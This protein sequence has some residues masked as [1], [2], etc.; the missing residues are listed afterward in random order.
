MAFSDKIKK[1]RENHGLTQI[2]LA[3]KL[4]VTQRTISYYETGKG[5]PNIDIL[6]LLAKTFDVSLDYLLLESE[7]SDIKLYALVNK[8]RMDTRRN[9]LI[10]KPSTD[11]E[12]C[13][14]MDT[15][16]EC[17]CDTVDAI[18]KI[19]DFKKYDYLSIDF[20]NSYFAEYKNGGYLLGLITTPEKNIT[21]AL[22]AYYKIKFH[23]LADINSM[24]QVEELYFEVKDKCDGLGEFL[25]DY[26][27]N[28]SDVTS[29]KMQ[30]VKPERK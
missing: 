16:E 25:N 28:S 26:L 24:R 29:P 6:N 22:F 4:G 14:E 2:D 5:Q 23:L 13:I 20:E 12:A 1:L 19:E 21:I 11:A 17:F 8:L 10:W 3:K 27:S 7:K 9:A 15:T 18:F 30:S